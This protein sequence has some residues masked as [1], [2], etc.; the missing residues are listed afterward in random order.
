MGAVLRTLYTPHPSPT[1][2]DLDGTS[3]RSLIKEALVVDILCNF[4]CDL[5]FLSYISLSQ[6]AAAFD[7]ILMD[8]WL[9]GCQDEQTTLSRCPFST[10]ISFFE[11]RH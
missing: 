1:S 8:V 5:A 4:V 10:F 3:T 9:L 6:V 11:G 2:T 7:L